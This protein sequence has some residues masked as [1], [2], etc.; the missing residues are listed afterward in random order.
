MS[1]KADYVRHG[2]YIPND[3][4]DQIRI[5]ADRENRSINKQLEHILKQWLGLLSKR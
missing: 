3:L 1:T 4:L 5:L 2:L